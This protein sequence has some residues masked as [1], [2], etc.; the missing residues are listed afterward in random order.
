MKPYR[1]PNNYGNWN[2]F[3]IALNSFCSNLSDSTNEQIRQIVRG[4]SPR[5][6]ETT[7]IYC[8]KSQ[9]VEEL[10]YTDVH[11][12]SGV[13]T[14]LKVATP[15]MVL[16]LPNG[17]VK[18]PLNEES[19]VTYLS[20]Q[21]KEIEDGEYKSEITWLSVD[22]SRDYLLGIRRVRYDGST[23][24]SDAK[25]SAWTKERLFS[26]QNLI[27]QSL[28]VL[29]TY[30]E[31]VEYVKAS[32]VQ[33]RK[34][35]STNSYCLPRWLGS[36]KTKRIYSSS[37]GLGKTGGTVRPHIRSGHWRTQHYGRHN[38]FSKMLWIRPVWVNYALV[39]ESDEI[40]EVFTLQ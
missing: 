7:P 14:E 4:L 16:F 34:G 13:L 37:S 15:K 12:K 38:Q 6:M 33:T 21:H 17:A 39:P 3:A 1:I 24:C 29:Q 25:G 28:M 23:K 11:E 10:G 30:P 36:G 9:L 22:S 40:Q 8:I 31:L 27:L 20:I 26:L 5:V 2:E 19:Y 32:E 18:S 35:E